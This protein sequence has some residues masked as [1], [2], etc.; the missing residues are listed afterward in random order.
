[1]SWLSGWRCPL[2]WDVMFIWL[3]MSLGPGCHGCLVGDVP[4]AGMSLI[5]TVRIRLSASFSYNTFEL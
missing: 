5:Q 1:M 4:W 3:E 2:V